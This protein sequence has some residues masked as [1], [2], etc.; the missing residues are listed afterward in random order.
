MLLW[1]TS[2]MKGKGMVCRARSLRREGRMEPGEDKL[3]ERSQE[4]TR[5]GKAKEW[6]LDG[7]RTDFFTPRRSLVFVRVWGSFPSPMPH[8]LVPGTHARGPRCKCQL[9]VSPSPAQAPI[10]SPLPLTPIHTHLGW[11]T[12]RVVNPQGSKERQNQAMRGFLPRL[13]IEGHLFKTEQVS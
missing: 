3:K 8:S 2:L 13:Q 4:L 5:A 6:E 10:L 9:K 1:A 7:P 12:C 11:G